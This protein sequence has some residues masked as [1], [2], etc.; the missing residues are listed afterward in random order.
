VIRPK[1]ILI[2]AATLILPRVVLAQ[3]EIITETGTHVA[4]KEHPFTKAPL[5]TIVGPEGARE[6]ILPAR[7]IDY[8]RPDYRMLEKSVKPNDVGYAGPYSSRKKVYILA[9]TLA[10]TGAVAAVALPAAFPAAAGAGA[11]G[12]ALGP[13]I[14]AVAVSTGAAAA[15]IKLNPQD[16]PDDVI[17]ESETV[18]L[19]TE[20]DFYKLHVSR[21]TERSELIS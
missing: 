4:V 10:T 7:E 3:N 16:M 12:S 18:L 20:T 17:R 9:A 8:G 21:P 1:L 15:A 2:L 5:V 14:G 11:A 6:D 19:E 13:G